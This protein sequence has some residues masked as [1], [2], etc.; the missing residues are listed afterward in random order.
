MLSAQLTA[1]CQSVRAHTHKK[2]QLTS[3]KA[4]QRLG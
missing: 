4:W 1:L 2:E 3:V